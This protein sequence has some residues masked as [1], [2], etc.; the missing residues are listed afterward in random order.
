[1]IYGAG[2]RESNR[3][4]LPQSDGRSITILSDLFK[5]SIEKESD[6]LTE[7]ILKV[8]VGANR[9]VGDEIEIADNSKNGMVE[10][11]G[12]ITDLSVAGGIIYA[13][14]RILA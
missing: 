7:K 11:V 13:L 5:C 14:V 9:K 4:N 2:W 3:T 8:V 1:M 12:V 10:F 6:M